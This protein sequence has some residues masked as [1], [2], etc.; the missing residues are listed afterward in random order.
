MAAQGLR[1]RPFAETSLAASDQKRAIGVAA[2]AMVQSGQTI[3]LDVGT[4]TAA[5]AQALIDRSEL[6]DVVIV[7]NALNIAV[8]LEAAVPRFTVIVTG[9][10]LRPLQH[11]LVAPLA[12]TV[13]QHVRADIAFIGCSGIDV[14]AGVTNVNLPEAEMKRMMLATASKVVVVADPSKLGVSQN[15]RVAALAEIDELITSDD[16][17]PTQLAPFLDA[18]LSVT[19]AVRA[20]SVRGD[21]S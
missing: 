11:S 5:V 14:D 17:D 4:T 6:S 20:Q 21:E 18:Q 2:A 19:L 7:T 9:G 10:S 13:L 8:T 3:I 15:S 1:E 12:G 16:A